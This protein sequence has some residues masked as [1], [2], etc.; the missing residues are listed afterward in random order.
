MVNISRVDL[1]LFVVFDAIYTEGGISR[2][3]AELKL[4]QSAISHALARLRELLKDPLFVRQGNAMVPTQLAN[5]LIAPVRRALREIEGS[6]NQLNSFDPATS[7]KQFK[8]GLRSSVE[9]VMFPLLVQRIRAQAPDVELV[10]LHHDRDTLQGQL[11]TGDV[12]IILDA[13]LPRIQNVSF[14]RLGWGRLVVAC[15]QD[16]P[17]VTEALDLATYLELDHV[18]ATSRRRGRGIEDVALHKL[19]YQRRVKVRCQHY[20]TACQLVAGS[21]LIAT[22]PEQFARSIN[23]RLGNRVVP[24]PL[25]VPAYDL[26]VYWHASAEA[27]PANRWLREQIIATHRD[28]L[29]APGR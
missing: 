24:F 21:D 29:V 8:I 15:R 9:A 6:L 11:A 5:E 4:T 18:L 23:D 13:L 19:G 26:Y 14:L 25:D 22:L 20:W 12:D 3:S 17:R 28:A 10:S 16:H 27:D 7:R 1:N 2:A